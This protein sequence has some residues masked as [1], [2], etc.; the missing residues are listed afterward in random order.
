MGDLLCIDVSSG[1]DER[2]AALIRDY[3]PAPRKDAPN[4]KQARAEEQAFVKREQDKLAEL[5]KLLRAK[6]FQIDR[7]IR[8]AC[9]ARGTALL[10]DNLEVFCP[11]C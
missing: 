8:V 5:V 7:Y 3:H 1:N 10:T 11:A 9:P 4:N 2:L 6:R